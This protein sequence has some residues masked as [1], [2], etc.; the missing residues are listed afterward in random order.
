MFVLMNLDLKR[1][2][3]FTKWVV[4]GGIVVIGSNS[5]LKQLNSDFWDSMK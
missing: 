2:W 1:K 5:L 3:G 4:E